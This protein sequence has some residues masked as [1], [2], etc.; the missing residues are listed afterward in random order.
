MSAFEVLKSEWDVAR[1]KMN[2]KA[3]LKGNFLWTDADGRDRAAPLKSGVFVWGKRIFN[4]PEGADR[5][6]QAALGDL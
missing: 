1:Q 5:A 4:W 2:R 6:M 3:R